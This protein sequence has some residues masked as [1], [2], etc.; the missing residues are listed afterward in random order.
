[1]TVDRRVLAAQL[2]DLAVLIPSAGD[3]LRE[4]AEALAGGFPVSAQWEADIV[5]IIYDGFEAPTP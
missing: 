2:A 3:V 4:A 5:R 1:M